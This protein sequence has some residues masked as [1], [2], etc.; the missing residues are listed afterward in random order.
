MKFYCEIE[1]LHSFVQ[2]IVVAEDST[3]GLLIL[4]QSTT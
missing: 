1:H 2:S 4:S 3:E